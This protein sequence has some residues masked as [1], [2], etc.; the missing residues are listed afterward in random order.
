MRADQVE[1]A[2]DPDKNNWLLRISIGEEV[3]RR[4]CNAPKDASDE[5]LKGLVQETLRDDGYEGDPAV[6]KIR[7]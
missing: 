1:I 7:R 6:L 2:W 3:I 4:H 5:V